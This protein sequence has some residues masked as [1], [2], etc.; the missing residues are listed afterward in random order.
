MPTITIPRSHF[1]AA[2]VCAAVKDIRFY[3]NGAM[4]ETGAGE[5][6]NMAVMVATDGH[7]LSCSLIGPCDAPPVQVIIPRSMLESVAKHKP[8]KGES[9]TVEFSYDTQG[10]E[11]HLRAVLHDGTTY[12]AVA[13]D[14]HFPDWR[15]VTRATKGNGVG[16]VVDP[17]FYAGIAPFFGALCETTNPTTV[18]AGLAIDYHAISTPGDYAAQSSQQVMV[19]TKANIDAFMLIM[20]MRVDDEDAAAGM[21]HVRALVAVKAREESKAA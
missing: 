9:D 2:L 1:K 20:P 3:L 5:H 6:G 8:M 11:M 18:N 15:R 4:L 10:D 19:V 17:R 16:V 7:R 13:V 14:G 12:A 21:R